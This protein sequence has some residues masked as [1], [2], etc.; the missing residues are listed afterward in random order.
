MTRIFRTLL[1]TALVSAAY[2]P[3]AKA[4]S[5]EEGHRITC[6]ELLASW[7]FR[8]FTG[9]PV[10]QA[11]V[12]KAASQVM[13][14]GLRGYIL[15]MRTMVTSGMAPE[16]LII[17]WLGII[18]ASRAE[19]LLQPIYEGRVRLRVAAKVAG[20]PERVSVWRRQGNKY[21]IYVRI[22]KSKGFHD[23]AEALWQFVESLYEVYNY[24][25]FWHLSPD[26]WQ[27]Q[28]DVTQ[29]MHGDLN[30]FLVA[31]SPVSAAA[32]R[33]D[34]EESARAVLPGVY[35]IY[36]MLNRL[37][38]RGIDLRDEDLP[39]VNFKDIFSVGIP[40]GYMSPFSSN[41]PFHSLNKED[42]QNALKNARGF[43]EDITRRQG[44]RMTLGFYLEQIRKITF[45]AWL[46]F[47]GYQVQT[48]FY[49][50]PVPGV[51]ES[52]DLPTD[53]NDWQAQQDY[54]AMAQTL[55]SPSATAAEK[56]D[57]DSEMKELRTEYCGSVYN[58][59]FKVPSK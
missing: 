46:T 32:V 15:G 51:I 45:I 25:S 6:G 31:F 54:T 13:A 4:D 27:H 41:R 43:V 50:D 57:A 7:T 1:L 52:T 42:A 40:V 30:D 28:S 26:I 22:P 2:G 58:F 11:K 9:I 8:S 29:K 19:A 34:W 16:D 56:S 17:Q 37:Q 14:K 10:D 36:N 24:R 53:Q 47:T 23:Q 59:C 5:V 49:S 20:R 38:K 3:V 48:F 33:A 18:K 12:D 55:N 21:D 39:V 35:R 44:R